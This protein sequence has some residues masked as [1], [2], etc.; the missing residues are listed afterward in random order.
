MVNRQARLDLLRPR[1]TEQQIGVG[2]IG[3]QLVERH[4]G[5]DG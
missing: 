4:R 3:G 1:N 5:C 2:R